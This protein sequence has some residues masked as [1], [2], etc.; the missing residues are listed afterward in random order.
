MF[1]IYTSNFLAAFYIINNRRGQ[2]FCL[3]KYE[4]LYIAEG[5]FTSPTLKIFMAISKL[6]LCSLLNIGKTSLESFSS[7]ILTSWHS[8]VNL[9]SEFH[10]FDELLDNLIHPFQNM[11]H[12]SFK[13]FWHSGSVYSTTL[14]DALSSSVQHCVPQIWQFDL[15]VRYQTY[16]LH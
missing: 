14:L 16:S 4:Y 8:K 13:G 2:N 9:N 3:T 7:I 6:T 11:F 10:R 5:S 12:N 1:Y 15:P